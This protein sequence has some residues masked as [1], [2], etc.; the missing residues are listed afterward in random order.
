MAYDQ[1]VESRRL[2]A[3]GPPDTPYRLSRRRRFIPLA[4]DVDGD[5][6]A[7]LF[8]RRGVSGNPHLEA[9]ALE[10]REGDWVVLGGGSGDGFDELF[11]PRDAMEGQ[12]RRLGGGW[13]LRG[14]DRLLP[15]PRRGISHFE[16]RLGARVA[17][18]EVG[19][20]RVEV[21]PHGVAIVVWRS[22]NPPT[23]RLL[24]ATGGP[25]EIVRPPRPNL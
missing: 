20:R 4:V 10:R 21:A 8:V 9:W 11:E 16:M 22:R 15:W 13:T 24:A 7:T 19:Q 12:L 18:L 23:I 1:L 3:E 17:S 14:S 25:L 6:A 2:I 5:V